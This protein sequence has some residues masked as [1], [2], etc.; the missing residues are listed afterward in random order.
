MAVLKQFI[1]GNENLQEI[2]ELYRT[3]LKDQCSEMFHSETISLVFYQ[4]GTGSKGLS[5]SN[6]R[7]V[8]VPQLQEAFN[9]GSKVRDYSIGV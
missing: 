2:H 6:N 8:G 1:K 7:M 3:L 4:K 9:S 5:L